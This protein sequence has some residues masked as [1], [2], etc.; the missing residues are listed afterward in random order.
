MGFYFYREAINKIIII[1]V[2]IT[3]AIRFSSMIVVMTFYLWYM[4]SKKL[5]V[6]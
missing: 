4:K 6:G 2:E 3:T 5:S 1:L